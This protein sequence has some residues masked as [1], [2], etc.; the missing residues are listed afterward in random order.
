[1]HHQVPLFCYNFSQTTSKTVVTKT[2]TLLKTVVTIPITTMENERCFP[3]LNWVQIFLRNTMDQDK[4]T[5]WAMLSNAKQFTAP[6]SDIKQKVTEVYSKT[7]ITRTVSNT[8]EMLRQN[9]LLCNKITFT[10]LL[11]RSLRK[12]TSANNV[13]PWT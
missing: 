7:K 12:H 6:T 5:A 9:I 10:V 3:T 4:L 1:M 8:G 13:H 2:V 11:C